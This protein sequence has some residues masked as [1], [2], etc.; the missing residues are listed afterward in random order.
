MKTMKVLTIAV[1]LLSLAACALPE[2]PTKPSGPAKPVNSL[3]TQEMLAYEA[4]YMLVGPERNKP[5]VKKQ[6]L[7]N[8]QLF[9]QKPEALQ[10][11]LSRAKTRDEFAMVP[12]AEL[13]ERTVKVGFSFGSDE[14]L[15]TPEQ[16]FQLRQ[17][18]AVAD[19]VE[20]RGR[21]DGRG[22]P[23]ADERIAHLRA[24]AAKRYLL[25]RNVPSSIIAI[26]YQ[27]AG[28]YIADNEKTA[29]RGMNRRVELEF[30]IDDFTADRV[31]SFAI[32][33]PYKCNEPLDKNQ[34]QEIDTQSRNGC[35]N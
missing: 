21:T 34:W 10:R 13:V 30:Y 20:V 25:D 19:R 17:L 6:F 14:F 15:P 31:Q 2:R 29:G 28:D 1:T 7:Y 16:R 18:L 3:A 32:N 33:E 4:G 35:I 27:A 12:G 26:N 23:A 9:N 11:Q 24:E 5:K 8:G 22:N